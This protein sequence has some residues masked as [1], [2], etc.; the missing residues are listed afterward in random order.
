MDVVAAE[1]NIKKLYSNNLKNK[2]MDLHLNNKVALVL[3]ASKDLGKAI[4]TSLSAEGAKVIIGSRNAAELEKTATEITPQTG[5]P[6][7]A[8][9]VDI[10]IAKQLADV[11]EKAGNMYGQIDI[12][13]NNAGGPPFDRFENFTDEQWQ[14]VFELNLLSFARQ[15]A[16]IAFHEKG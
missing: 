13:I 8:M 6:V 16:G 12:L 10:S 4:K 3:A 2:F 1:P 11:I 9:T 15:Q 7:T 5:N 14:A